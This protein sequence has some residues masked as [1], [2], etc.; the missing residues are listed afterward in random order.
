MLA[1]GHSCMVFQSEL[2]LLCSIIPE[3]YQRSVYD[4]IVQP[5]LDSV[6]NEGEVFSIYR[7]KKAIFS[8]TSH[9]ILDV[10]FI[11]KNY[12]YYKL[13]TAAY[14]FCCIQMNASME[15]MRM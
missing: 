10:R 12:M 4:N 6:V 9:F 3:K 15:F 5:G 8:S 11:K 7:E 13:G 14:S 1:I 2:Q